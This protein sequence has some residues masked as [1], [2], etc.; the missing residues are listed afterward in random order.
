MTFEEDFKQLEFCKFK[1]GLGHKLEMNVAYIHLK[2]N[3]LD[4]QKVKKLL[5]NL[6]PK[7]ITGVYKGS[8]TDARLSFEY[9]LAL[10]DIKKE[11]GLDDT[12]FG[13]KIKTD[14]KLKYN[15]F[16]LEL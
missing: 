1:D 2:K 3:A 15:D 9:Y 10:E 8:Y 12:L 7:R 11:L 4:K 6:Q 13:M 16:R 14:S 5:E